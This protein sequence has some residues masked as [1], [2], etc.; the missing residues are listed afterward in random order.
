MLT[1]FPWW[2]IPICIYPVFERF[3]KRIALNKL[4]HYEARNCGFINELPI[5]SITCGSMGK[6]KTT[7][8]TDMSLSQEV[9]FRQ[10]ALSIL[11]NTDLKFPYF[12]WI[13]F[14]KE[15][16]GG[17]HLRDKEGFRLSYY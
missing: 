13:C 10:K 11:Q 15:L 14:E 5:V 6:R 3:R 17:Q 7:V 8:I 12:P 2:V 4:R 1:Y 9:M 16:Q